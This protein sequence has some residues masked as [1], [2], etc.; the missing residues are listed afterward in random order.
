MRD[1]SIL[2]AESDVLDPGYEPVTGSV[3]IRRIDR[4]D[5]C[6]VLD[7]GTIP[8]GGHVLFHRTFET[9][10]RSFDLYVEFCFEPGA[11]ALERVNDVLALLRIGRAAP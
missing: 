9:G 6:E 4:C 2:L 11:A 7:D 5:G 1:A 10:G 3:S 8:P